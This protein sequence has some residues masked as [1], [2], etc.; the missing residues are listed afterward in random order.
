MKYLSNRN[1]LNM[2][3]YISGNNYRNGIYENV[4]V[5]RNVLYYE[6]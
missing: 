6:V 4:G 5:T 3:E 2:F 1:K